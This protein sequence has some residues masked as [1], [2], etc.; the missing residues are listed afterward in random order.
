[1]PLPMS[2]LG[3]CRDY[4]TVVVRLVGVLL[5]GVVVV[6]DRNRRRRL[7]LPFHRDDA[8]AHVIALVA[9]ALPC[10]LPARWSSAWWFVPLL[11]VL[12]VLWIGVLSRQRHRRLQREGVL[13]R[14]VS[15][16]SSLPVLGTAH[17]AWVVLASG[18][19]ERGY[20]SNARPE[21]GVLV[22]RSPW[23]AYLAGAGLFAACAWMALLG[24]L[25]P[26][27]QLHAMYL[28]PML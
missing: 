15:R 16:D 11:T 25:G 4:W 12:P 14:D 22:P 6:V 17:T 13:V 21:I 28:A 18:T 2:L 8:R 23:R 24:P 1:M 10:A 19:L 27:S 26:V 5:V 20:R 7:Q 3:T 9:F